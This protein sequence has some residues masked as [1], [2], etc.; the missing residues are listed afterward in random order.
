MKEENVNKNNSDDIVFIYNENEPNYN[1][2]R[3]AFDRLI[4]PLA[5]ATV[6]EEYGD[7]RKEYSEALSVILRWSADYEKTQTLIYIQ[8]EELLSIYYKLRELNDELIYTSNSEMSD[9]IVIW[10][11]DLMLLRKKQ[12][13]DWEKGKNNNE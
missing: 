6:Y 12:I 10:L 3:F 5:T 9:Q 11:W 7:N 13:E 2:I 4:G 1:N 8:R